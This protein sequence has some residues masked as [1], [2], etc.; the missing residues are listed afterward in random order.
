MVTKKVICKFMCR[1]TLFI[2]LTVLFVVFYM[3]DQMSDY[4]SNR[5]TISTRIEELTSL[6]FPTLIICMSSGQKR[7]VARK[8]GAAMSWMFFFDNKNILSTTGLGNLSAVRNQLSYILN[9][10]FELT[11][12][13]TK[14]HKGK[15]NVADFEL[16]VEP[17][18]TMQYLTCYKI[19]LNSR[20]DDIDEVEVPF[21]LDME[22]LQT[23][24]NQV[25]R[26]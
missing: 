25:L 16:D 18:Y 2:I 5:S 15:N 3:Q 1:A 22:V 4:L 14:L 13:G 9:R 17:I 12:S 24:Q 21:S 20:K 8:F 6:E 19:K 10:D 23:V 7:S 11:A 26:C